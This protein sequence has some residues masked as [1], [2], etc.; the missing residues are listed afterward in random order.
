M[1]GF[2]C[3]KSHKVSAAAHANFIQILSNIMILELF[4]YTFILN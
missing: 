1:V 3:G 4:I 2:S